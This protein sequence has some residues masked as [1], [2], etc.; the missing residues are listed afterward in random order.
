MQYEQVSVLHSSQAENLSL[1]I[2]EAKKDMIFS[3]V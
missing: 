2:T 3:S 1:N